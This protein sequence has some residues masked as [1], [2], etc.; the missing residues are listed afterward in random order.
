MKSLYTPLI[1]SFALAASLG[2]A[3]A[4]EP[5]APLSGEAP[6]AFTQTGSSHTTRADV[7]AQTAAQ[8][9]LAGNVQPEP[10]RLARSEYTR[11]EV[12]AQAIQNPPLAGE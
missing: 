4:A 2:S 10:Q 1:A 6:Y 5:M 3:W 8:A 11:A 7:Q 9:P 12:R